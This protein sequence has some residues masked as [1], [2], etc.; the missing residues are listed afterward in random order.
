MQGDRTS[1]TVQS[2]QTTIDLVEYLREVGEAGVTEMATALDHSKGTVHSHLATLLKNEYVVKNGDQYELSLKFIDLGEYAKSRLDI[3]DVVTDELDD[4][5]A[6]TGEVAQFATE[7]HGRAVYLYKA[8]GDQAVNTASSAG[9][10]EYIHCISLGKAML[11]QFPDER[12]HEIIDRHG[13]PAQ[14]ANTITDSQQ[15]EEELREIRERGYAIDDEEMIEGIRCV[16]APLT[17]DKVVGAI[18]I[19]GPSSRMQ[20][21]RFRENL[22]NKLLRSANVIEINAKFS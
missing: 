16:A 12:V 11:A 20:G 7:E 18:S 2:V 3:Y 14:T 5:A 19:S 1:R 13:L 9:K 10:R 22:P 6:E 8:H 17:N 4:L 15:L 21:E